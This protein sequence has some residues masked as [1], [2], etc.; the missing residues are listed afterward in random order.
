VPEVGETLRIAR[1]RAYE[2][3][4]SGEIPAIKI[5]RNI[6]VSFRDEL[7]GHGPEHKDP[8][9]IGQQSGVAGHFEEGERTRVEYGWLPHR[10]RRGGGVHA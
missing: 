1:S 2:L 5:G 8:V 9:E 10:S 4:G 6:Q 3:V 7:F